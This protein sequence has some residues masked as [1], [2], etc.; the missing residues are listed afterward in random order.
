MAE[1]MPP[2]RTL[3][4]QG[5]GLATASLVLAIASLPLTILFFTGILTAILSISLGHV[6]LRQ[7]RHSA[8]PLPTKNKAIVGLVISYLYLV[9]AIVI[10]ATVV[11]NRVSKTQFSDDTG[12]NF[13]IHKPL[14]GTSYEWQIKH[15]AP[16]VVVMAPIDVQVTAQLDVALPIVPK[17]PSDFQYLSINLIPKK[18]N[19]NIED[20]ARQLTSGTLIFDKNY[21]AEDPKILTISGIPSALFREYLVINGS[22]AKGIAFLVPCTRG[23]YLL[24][25]RCDPNSYDESFYKRIASTFKPKEK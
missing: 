22:H 24:T 15:R 8:N 18:Y 23:Y 17:N 10:V 19:G 6:A 21:S 7:A 4:S 14:K 2:K 13:T 5:S 12:M 20:V 3:K 16:L 11:A 9:F 1:S 25:F